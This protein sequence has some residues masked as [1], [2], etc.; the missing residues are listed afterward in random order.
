MNLLQ[1][2]LEFVNAANHVHDARSLEI[3][4]Q[5]GAITLDISLRSLSIEIVKI[6][7]P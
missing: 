1:L 7:L 2:W 3:W 4:Y 6:I 5:I